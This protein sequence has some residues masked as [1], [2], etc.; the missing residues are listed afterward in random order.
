MTLVRNIRSLKRAVSSS[1]VVAPNKSKRARF[2]ASSSSVVLQPPKPQIVDP[3]KYNALTEALV[4]HCNLN[5]I[6]RDVFANMESIPHEYFGHLTDFI[7]RSKLPVYGQMRRNQYC[8][9]KSLQPAGNGFLNMVFLDQRKMAVI[10]Y[11]AFADLYRNE[12][13]RLTVLYPERLIEEMEPIPV[14]GT[15]HLYMHG[16]AMRFVRGKNLLML[17]RCVVRN[18]REEIIESFRA[19]TQRLLTKGLVFD[20][21]FERRMRD[22]LFNVG[23]KILHFVDLEN[24]LTKQQSSFCNCSNEEIITVQSNDFIHHLDKIINV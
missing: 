9:D 17:P 15:S 23:D 11:F 19:E 18:C 1:V 7:L 6:P 20:K 5:T 24:V 14:P 12:I 21:P 22:F 16:F 13:N 8:L 10:K 4:K 2:M 3:L